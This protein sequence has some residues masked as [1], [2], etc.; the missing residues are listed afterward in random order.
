MRTNMKMVI[1]L[2]AVLMIAS[3]FAVTISSGDSAAETGD[4]NVF[5]A[6][7][8]DLCDS[9]FG[10]G[11][12][13]ISVESDVVTIHVNPS[14]ITT[15]AADDDVKNAIK[16]LVHDYKYIYVNGDSIVNN[17]KPDMAQLLPL[18]I[19]SAETF[20]SCELALGDNEIITYDVKTVKTGPAD[21]SITES[22]ILRM[23]V[24]FTDPALLVGVQAVQ[25]NLIVSADP[26]VMGFDLS[27]TNLQDIVPLEAYGSMDVLDYLMVLFSDYENLDLGNMQPVLDYSMGILKNSHIDP[28]AAAEAA[29]KNFTH[30]ATTVIDN[31]SEKYYFAVND[32]GSI[33]TDVPEGYVCGWTAPV[34]VFTEGQIIA[35]AV[36][37][38]AGNAIIEANAE[39]ILPTDSSVTVLGAT[40]S[41]AE[42]MIGESATVSV[43]VDN[44]GSVPYSVVFTSSDETVVIVDPLTGDILAVGPGV[45]TIG[46]TVPGNNTVFVDVTVT[47]SVEGITLDVD[48]VQM[49]VGDS[50]VLVAT[51]IPAQASDKNLL[52][53]SENTDVALV[54]ESGVVTAVGGG[55]TVITVITEDG[56][57]TAS[58][59]VEVIVHVTGITLDKEYVQLS[60]GETV[61]LVPIVLPDEAT[62]KSVMWESDDTSVV[63]VDDFGNIT[64]V[65]AGLTYIYATTV[66]GSYFTY[67]EVEVDSLYHYEVRY[68]DIDGMMIANVVSGSAAYGETV[69]GE[70]IDIPGYETPAES[71]SIVISD[72][73]SKN[74]IVYTYSYVPTPVSGVELNKTEMKLDVGK[75][76]TLV[77]TVLPTYAVIKNIFWSSSDESIVTVD[78][79]G[80]VV[81]VA[82]GVATITVTT[83]DG[84]FTATCEVTVPVHVKGVSLDMTSA[85]VA[86]GSEFTLVATVTPDNATNKAVSWSSSNKSV[87]TVDENGNVVVK[88]PGKAT[89]TVITKDK[90]FIATC[91]IV[92]IADQSY[93]VN[94]VDEEGNEI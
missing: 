8:R 59:I 85:S 7:V 33:V 28:V 74:I 83:V 63:I 36:T 80:S 4:G 76:S 57:F 1:G 84:G 49:D 5:A 62:D 58:C 52:W 44:P 35:P 9:V 39:V 51:V 66:D 60:I 56:G 64:A 46:A 24:E 21:E 53:V 47:V 79:F 92:A 94:Y 16:A 22:F 18:Q 70:L 86:V 45:A 89:I 3:S 48:Y 69:V 40:V 2:L 31:G 77:A 6:D 26:V 81:A 68:Q 82:E 25:S 87:A 78:Q 12:I 10:E 19:S 93:V 61:T 11:K 37:F 27:G 38:Y 50:Y 54:N 73:V 15:V 14:D 29:I 41:E 55:S 30:R 67:C 20:K 71:K 13:G 75:K 72:D 88:A 91:K 65:S 34:S 43:D 23:V 17:S 42:L 32:D 90:S